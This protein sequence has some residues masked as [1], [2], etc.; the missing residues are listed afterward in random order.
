MAWAKPLFTKKTIDAAG[1]ILAAGNPTNLADLAAWAK[2][3]EAVNI[4]NNWRAVHSYPLQMMKMSLKRRAK[5]IDGNA[6]VAQRLK[7]LTSIQLKLKLSKEAGNHPNLSQM[8]DIGGCRAVMKNVSQVRRVEKAFIEAS[9]KSPHRGPEYS[10]TT[11]YITSP[12]DNGYRSV[13]LLYKFRSTSPQ[14]SCYNGQRIEI[15][16]RS[17]HQHY[18]ATAVETYSTFAGEAL[19]SNIGSGEWKRFFAL[20]SSAI[21]IYEKTPCVPGTPVTIE[22]LRPELSELYVRLNVFNVLSGY[23]AAAKFTKDT[24]DEEMRNADAY[25]LVLDADQFTVNVTP[26]KRD[27]LSRANNEYARIEKEHP[28]LQVVLVSVDSLHGLRVAYPNY[29][30]DTAEFL[31]IVKAAIGEHAD[32]KHEH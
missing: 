21:A 23:S 12:K 1:E 14:H 11:D 9:K 24:T 29:F 3:E 20:V 31:S 22:G 26:Y 27:E 15:Q 6:I 30:L 8:Q 17:K 19:K 5:H 25:L 16:L 2:L 18:W 7:R 13:H 32:A 28:S 4:V 10:K